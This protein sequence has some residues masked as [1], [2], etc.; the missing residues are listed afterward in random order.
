M[1]GYTKV[2]DAPMD[3]TSSKLMFD[4]SHHHWYLVQCEKVGIHTLCIY[5]FF[6]KS[7]AHNI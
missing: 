1:L 6:L 4:D 5:L 3:A 7:T 2:I